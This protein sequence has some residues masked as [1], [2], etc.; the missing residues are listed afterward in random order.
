MPETFNPPPQQL[1]ESVANLVLTSVQL[2]VAGA[3]MKLSK[4]DRD[5]VQLG[6][7]AAV[8]LT[9]HAI[10]RRAE[11]ELCTCPDLDVATLSGHPAAQ[12]VKGHSL[13]CPVHGTA[14]VAEDNQG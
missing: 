13:H 1:V 2:K 7:V 14:A 9:W 8:G 6:A 12:T 4:H 11:R 3:G 5:M 10:V